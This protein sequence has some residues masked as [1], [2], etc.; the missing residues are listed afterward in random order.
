MRLPPMLRR[1]MSSGVLTVKNSTKV[2]TFTPIRIS[3]PYTNRR[4]MYV[5]IAS[6]S[7]RRDRHRT[8]ARGE[9]APRHPREQQRGGRDEAERPPHRVVPLRLPCRS[10][11]R[12]D[13]V[14]QRV[15]V[16]E[17]AELAV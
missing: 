8:L 9:G 12:V 5:S 13:P 17:Q 11:R 7:R 14:V 15:V 1:A 16:H 2:N 6:A 10:Q 4:T 3:S